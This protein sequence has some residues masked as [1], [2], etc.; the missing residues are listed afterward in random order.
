[1]SKGKTVATFFTHW[2][3]YNSF[4]LEHIRMLFP[5]SL[6]NYYSRNT[7]DKW[8]NSVVWELFEGEDDK[9]KNAEDR[10]QFFTTWVRAE[11]GFSVKISEASCDFYGLVGIG[12]HPCKSGFAY[13]IKMWSKDDFQRLLDHVERHREYFKFIRIREVKPEEI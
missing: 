10:T 1:M 2:W 4:S 13:I 9:V 6:S 8:G 5:S 7:P 11:N 3:Q 12:C